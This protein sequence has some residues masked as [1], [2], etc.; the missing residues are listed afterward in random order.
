M[1]SALVTQLGAG[2]GL[3][4]ARP[5]LGTPVLRRMLLERF[6]LSLF[7]PTVLGDPRGPGDV[8]THHL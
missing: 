3:A 7:L 1:I 6:R 8:Q 4:G 5:R 2:E